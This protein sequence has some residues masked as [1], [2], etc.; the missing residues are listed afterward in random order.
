MDIRDMHILMQTH[1]MTENQTIAETHCIKGG[2]SPHVWKETDFQHMQ[3][4]VL[5]VNAV[6][7]V[8]EE[9]H[10]GLVVRHEAG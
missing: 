4:E 10:G 9:H 2:C 6:D 3:Q 1:S 5:I 7:S 8:Q